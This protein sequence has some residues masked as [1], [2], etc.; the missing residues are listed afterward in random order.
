LGIKGTALGKKMQWTLAWFDQERTDVS[1]PSDPSISAFATSTTTEGAEAS[2]N[3]QPTRDWFI[4]AAVTYMEALYLSG[5]T[6]GQTVDVTARELGFQDIVAPNGD[7]YPA[8]AFGYGGRTRVLIDDPNNIYDEVP[9]SPKVQASLNTTYTIGKGFGLLANIQYFG[10][11]WANR[12]QTVEIPEATVYNVGATWDS[13]R[14]HLK[15]N[16][17]NLT[18]EIYFRA[19]NGSNAGLLSVMADRRYEISLKVDF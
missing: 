1:N 10:E 11:S 16:I 12:I 2:L 3:Y 14:V 13:A 18:D 8:E 17:Y 5:L 4:G 6:T 15:A 9:G 7:V 19:G